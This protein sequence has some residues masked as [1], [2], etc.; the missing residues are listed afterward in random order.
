MAQ[1]RT[2]HALVLGSRF[3]GLAV[4]SWLRRL[5]SPSRL[6]I[7]VIDQWHEMIFRP[8]LVHAMD[9]APD[10]LMSG[11]TIPLRPFWQKQKVRFLHDT[12]VGI[13]PS[14]REVY[15]ASH[16]P[17]RYDVLFIAT[18]SSP[19]WNLIPG[20]AL[21]HQ[22]ICEGYMAR[23]TATL[24]RQYP[25]GRLVFATGP[26]DAPNEWHPAINVGCECPLFE[27]A[28]LWDQHLRQSKQREAAEITVLTPSQHIV[29]MASPAVRERLQELLHKRN[30]RL[31]TRAA[32]QQVTDR[33]ITLARKEIPYDRMVWI[34]P[35]QGSQWL[36]GSGVDDGL[37]W[38]PTDEYLQH[39]DWP[40]IY[41]V[42]DVTSHPW[43]KMGH[44]A[45]VQ[46]R[47]AVHHWA[48]R[49]QRQRKK[50]RPYEPQFLWVLEVG[51]GDALFVL[52][53]KVYGGKREVILRG[54]TSYWAK[55]I[56]QWTYTQTA[57]ALPIM[58]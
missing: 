25:E 22:G 26:I 3:G 24:N 15:T 6:A 34:P 50:P 21:H 12:I 54:R 18:G 55:Q 5:Y 38:V 52:S 49:E 27:T 56:F 23:H 51:R 14:A 45:M 4:T 42:G 7:T 40:E 47:V 57:G 20:L 41:A 8:G 28:L 33:F 30:I 35:Q 16:A 29:E 31:V 1:S 36:R 17:V 32:F 19:G 9:T 10:T 43:P 48:W 46:A 39:P 53:N 11:V 58:P 37:G 44:A 2:Q 13:D